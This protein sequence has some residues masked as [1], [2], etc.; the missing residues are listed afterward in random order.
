MRIQLRKNSYNQIESPFQFKINELVIQ[1]AELES[2]LNIY[3][4][5][6]IEGTLDPDLSGKKPDKFIENLKNNVLGDFSKRYIITAHCKDEVIGILIAL[7]GRKNEMH[8][9]SLH[10]APDHRNKGVA[11]TLLATCVNDMHKKNIED[12]IIDV[13]ID[14]KP[15]YTLYKKFEFVEVDD[16]I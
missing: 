1:G 13:H 6:F 7:P 11:S 9:Y 15:A 5:R 14:N 8:I 3:L 16:K 10:V 2:K 4:S 12:I